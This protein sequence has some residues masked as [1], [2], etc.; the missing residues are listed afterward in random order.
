MQHP[1]NSERSHNATPVNN[2]INGLCVVCEQEIVH[3]SS[4]LVL[5]RGDVR[6]SYGICESCS[7]A[8]LTI[9]IGHGDTTTAVSMLTDFHKPEVEYFL[10]Q[11]AMTSDDVIALHQTI[12][13]PEFAALLVAS[14]SH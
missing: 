1:A 12:N 11:D 13:H 8:H 7:S 10:K 14:E 2:P 4:S 9:Q 5:D 6:C 3:D